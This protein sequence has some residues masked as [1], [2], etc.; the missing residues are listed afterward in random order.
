MHPLPIPPVDPLLLPLPP[1][2]PKGLLLFTF[3]LHL[4]AVNLGV[5]GSVLSVL[6][7]LRGRPG[8]L[9]LVRRVAPIL[10]PAVTFAI[11]LGVAPLLFVQLIY[12]QFFYSATVLTAV[13]WLALIFLLMAGYGLLYRFVGSTASDHFRLGSGV[14]GALLL[15]SI[16][17]VFVN[18]TTLSLRPDLWAAHAAASPHGGLP[19]FADPTLWPRFLHLGTG[20]LASAGMLMAGW[21]AWKNHA[22]A[23]QAG[24]RWFIGA[25]LTQAAW[26]TW[27]L[28]SQ[29]LP[30][31][32]MLTSGTAFGSLALWGAIACGALAT[33]MAIPAS[34]TGA[35]R[36]AVWPPFALAQAAV[37]GMVLMRDQARDT[38]FAAVGFSPY[39]LPYKTDWPSLAVFATMLVLLVVLLTLL[40]RWSLAPVQAGLETPH[41]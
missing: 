3:S 28:V 36:K 24:L 38:S 15:L 5:G 20:I 14:V 12:G 11:T 25:T 1:L 26:G 7:A 18:V 29:P 23:R 2:V 33:L 16:A 35:D 13:P 19:N 6:H 37:I 30:V 9:D 31:L 8:D 17:F 39:A 32:A 4:L 40:I 27:L 22:G 10:P 41:D 34:Q 21:G